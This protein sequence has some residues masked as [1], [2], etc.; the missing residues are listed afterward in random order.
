MKIP[1]FDISLKPKEKKYL[2]EV[3]KNDNYTGG[4]FIKKFEDE[5]GKINKSKF[6]IAVS[7]GTNAL[8]LCCIAVGIKKG[9]EVL[10]SSST[11]MASAFS[12]IYSGGIPI[13]IDVNKDTWQIDPDLIEKKI[14]KRT[15]AI[16]VVHLFGQSVEMDKILKIAKK[17]KLKV[18]EDC[19]EAHGVFYKKKH[20]GNFGDIAAFS[21]YFNKS[22]TSGE[23]GMVSTNSRKIYEFVKKYK[24]LCYGNKER[25]LHSGIG[26]NYRISNLQS[27]LGYGITKNFKDILKK[28]K[29]IYEYYVSKFKDIDGIDIPKISKNTSRYVMWV[30]NLCLNKKFPISR[31]DLLK[32][33]K[34]KGIETRKAFA[35]INYQDILIKKFKG[36]FNKRSCKNANFIMNNGFYL[37][38]G[39]NIRKKEIDFIYKQIKLLSSK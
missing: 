34:K 30:F 9:D 29:I 1:V 18:I 19:A 8:H 4:P 22:I 20:V 21:F 24:N 6:N 2:Y 35:P 16:M 32:K 23:G 33:L 25:F 7:N 3:I 14:S 17:Y 38:S 13:P 37:P 5:F 12:I 10:V 39:N 36:K 15:K 27:A 26:F 31:N 11:N 28:K